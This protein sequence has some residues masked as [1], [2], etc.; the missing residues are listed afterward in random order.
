M[1]EK[2]QKPPKGIVIREGQIPN[3]PPN[4]TKKLNYGAII[5]RIVN[6]A[7]ERLTDWELDFISSVYEWHILNGKKLSEKQQ[8]MIIK[9]NRRLMGRL[10]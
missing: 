8:E 9:I 6:T 4:L 2:L 10:I 7:Q 3:P 5:E 1:I